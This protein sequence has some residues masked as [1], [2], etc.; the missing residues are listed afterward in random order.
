M[1]PIVD[2]WKQMTS[3]QMATRFDLAKRFSDYVAMFS[4][5]IFLYAITRTLSSYID[6]TNNMDAEI[7]FALIF[8][9]YILVIF[10][11]AFGII[12]F[13]LTSNILDGIFLPMLRRDKGGFVGIFYLV[14]KSLT[15]GA[16]YLSASTAITLGL[17]VLFFRVL[18][19][20]LT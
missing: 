16:V 20:A 6:T 12:F 1:Q 13:F 19:K 14:V 9:K 18:T 4:R 11:T 7:K 15:I 10:T 8:F 2:L 17:N 5:L 3:E